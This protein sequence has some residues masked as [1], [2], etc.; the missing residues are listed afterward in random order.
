MQCVGVLA[1]QGSFAEHLHSLSDIGVKA[2]VVQNKADLE[3]VDRL[4]IPGGESTTIGKILRDTE[5]FYPLKEKIQ[6]GMP[7]WGTCAGCILLAKQVQSGVPQLECMNI[8]VERNAYGSQLD[9][10]STQEMIPVISNKLLNLIFIRAPKIRS[11]FGHAQVLCQVRGEIV[12][13]RENSM[14]VTTFHPELADGGDF[15]Q[16]FLQI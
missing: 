11:V 16:Y 12:A 7:V 10:F 6:N 3:R 9:S 2:L 8:R 15:H 14:F 1:L 5:L 4:I 13:V